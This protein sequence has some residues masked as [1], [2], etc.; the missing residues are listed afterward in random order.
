MISILIPS[1]NYNT[2]PLVKELYRQ[3]DLEN[4]EFEIIVQD[5]ASPINENTKINT[6]INQIPHCRFERN[7]VTL[8]RGQNRNSLVEKASYSW[9]LFLDCDTFPQQKHFIKNYLECIEKPGIQAVYGGIIYHKEKPNADEMLRWV[10]GKDREEIPLEKRVKS[11]YSYSLISNFLIQRETLKKHPFDDKLLQY[12]YEDIVLIQDLKQENIAIAQI[13][14]PVYHLQLENSAIFLEKTKHSLQNL[15]FLLDEKIFADDNTSLIKTYRFISKIG[16]RKFVVSLF[17][18]SESFLTKNLLSE[19]P[20]L[21]L[22][23]LYKLGYFCQ[24]NS[25]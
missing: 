1:Y 22:F 5:D 10:Y 23:L 8:G 20:S 16:L 17:K 2:L 4:I 3:L 25:R 12:G 19:K 18:K 24:L 13:E 21:N 6:G 11:P 9:L 7:D 15:K 14:N